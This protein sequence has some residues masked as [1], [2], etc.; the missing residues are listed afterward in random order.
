MNDSQ[1]IKAILKNSQ[2]VIF[3]WRAEDGWPVEYVSENVSL[4]GYQEQDFLSGRIPY[5]SIIHPDDIAQV[6]E[7]VTTY[8]Q[9]KQDEFRQVYRVLDAQGK[10]RWIDDRTV[11]E[12]D[13]AGHPAYYVGTIIDISD[14]KK[15]E[16]FSQL[17]GGL[18]NE[19]SEEAYV[20]ERD[21]L[22]FTYLNTAALNNIGF[23][24]EEAKNLTPFDIKADLDFV[25]FK[26][27]LA[28][29]DASN[30]KNE[31]VEFEAIMKRKDG[32]EYCA[33]VKIQR[34]YIDGHAHF[35]AIV[36]DV[37][38]RKYLEE[39]REKEHQFVQTVI[40]GVA[41]SIMVI[42]PDYTVSMMNKAAKTMLDLAPIQ[43]TDSPKCYEISHHRSKPCDGQSH[44]CPLHM[45]MQSKTTVSVIHNHGNSDKAHYVELTAKPLF[46]ER[47]EVY[48]IV[49]SSHDITSLIETQEQ[50]IEQTAKMSHQA[51]HDSL[52]GLP[53]RRLFEDRLRQALLRSKRTIDCFAVGLIDVD[54]FKQIN[55][56][57][58]H[59]A[60]DEVLVEVANRLRNTL[61]TSD[62]VARLG[63]DEFTVIIESIH[64]VDGFKPIF[65]KLIAAFKDPQSKR[66][67]LDR[68]RFQLALAAVFTRLMRRRMRA[69]F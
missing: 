64:S 30:Q 33:D 40:D 66:L 12:R 17:L 25:D 2:A 63:G 7:E 41:D 59:F 27:K 1:R 46:N 58:G 26:E 9:T 11:I 18:L 55:D 65:E 22:K 67:F 50:L 53:N 62:T 44:P 21:S 14:Q 15:A 51:G 10:I 47:H 43:N 6:F 20:F 48:S 56:T 39:Q 38:N 19:S 54:K 16:Q 4:F 34:V 69:T 3:Y 49:E 45:V 29:L 37:S 13:E 35:F 28:N 42:Q 60:G 36:H 32:S 52:T 61:R 68:F 23:S 5:S 31:F 57:F 8:T 24:L